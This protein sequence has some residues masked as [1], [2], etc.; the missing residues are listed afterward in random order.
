MT[1]WP[2]VQG[3]W[4]LRS[5][6]GGSHP[7]GATG[8]LALLDGLGHPKDGTTSWSPAIVLSLPGEEEA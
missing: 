4:G 7:R 2:L 3:Y 1:S 8:W 5:L 6:E